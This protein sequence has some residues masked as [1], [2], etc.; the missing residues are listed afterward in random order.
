MEEFFFSMAE[1]LSAYVSD[2]FIID[3][4]PGRSSIGRGLLV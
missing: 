4:P 3:T 1:D 2:G